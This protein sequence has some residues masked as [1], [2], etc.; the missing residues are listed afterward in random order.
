MK[1]TYIFCFLFLLFIGCQ[2][3][4]ILISTK[5]SEVFYVENQGASTRVFVAG[6]P[7]SHI[8]IMI[9]HGGPG[10][11]S[12]FYDTKYISRHLGDKYAMVYWDQRNAGASQGTSNGKVLHLGIMVEDLKKVIEVLKFRYGQNISL[13]LVGHSFGGLIAA[14]FVTTPGYQEMIKG[15]IDVDGSHNYPLNDT[16]TREML[17]SYGK[18]EIS[19]R[20]KVYQWVPIINYCLA[21]QGNFSEDE[22]M[23]LEKYA[24]DAENLIDSVK[25]VNITSFILRY[26]ITDEYPLT[27]ILSNLLYSEDSNFNKELAVTQFSSLLNTVTIPVLVLWGKY[28]FV[29]PI[30]IGEDFY[31]RINS[32]NKRFVISPVSGHNMILQDKKLFCDEIDMFVSKNR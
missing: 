14:D 28:D 17:L 11:S 7:A 27:S 1:R 25:K 31:N 12:Y 9:I 3:E 5:A 4:S 29:C 8:F 24:G 23:Q 13:Y 21:H 19:L 2:K 32:T 20:R 6:N 30:Q 15:L 10:V 18:R 16:L 26:A 22:S